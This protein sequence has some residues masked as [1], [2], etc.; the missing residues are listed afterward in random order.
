MGL[1]GP[2]L[3]GP[4]LPG[5]AYWAKAILKYLNFKLVQITNITLKIYPFILSKKRFWK[6]LK[7]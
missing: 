4:G 2:G 6:P 3:M 7:R 1:M 5:P